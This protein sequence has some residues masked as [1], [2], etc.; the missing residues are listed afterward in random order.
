[1]VWKYWMLVNRV[2][3][4]L[5]E[6]AP[7]G[8]ECPRAADVSWQ[9]IAK[10][11]WPELKA[12]QL[13]MHAAVCDHC[14]PLLR[15]ATRRQ[16]SEDA[17]LST[18]VDSPRDAAR[19]SGPNARSLWQAVRLIG[20]ALVLIA[21]AAAWGLKSSIPLRQL[22]GREIAEFAVLNHRKHLRH[23]ASLD[24]TTDSLATLNTWLKAN[25]QLSLSLPTSAGVP[26]ESHPYSLEGARLLRLSGKTAV[27][28]AYQPLDRSPSPR[29]SLTV[30]PDSLGVASG[31]AVADFKK[32]S[33]HYSMVRK[34]KVVTWSLH[35]LT[36][37]LVSSEG[38]ATQKSCMV[39]HSVM[40]DR[41]LTD[42]PTPLS[43][44]GSVSRPV[45]Q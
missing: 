29:V 14:G 28:I 34:Y 24:L 38:P 20:P 6:N 42:V 35:G 13:M 2:S 4:V 1:M 26:D 3:T 40:K 37:S 32:V 16:N 12:T 9:E 22:S 11:L 41:D 5:S 31:G 27:F 8:P 17:L 36:Y 43:S 45:W 21:I 7:P 18:L 30:T 15:E 10:G 25:S 44:Y 33:F 19:L 39:C 23:D